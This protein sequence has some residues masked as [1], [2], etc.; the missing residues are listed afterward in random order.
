MVFYK[1]LN[2]WPASAVSGVP[3]CTETY[4][5]QMAAKYLTCEGT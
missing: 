4:M 5:E 1:L 3:V 2:E